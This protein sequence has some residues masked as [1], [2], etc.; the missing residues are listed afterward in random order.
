[1]TIEETV[2]ADTGKTLEATDVCGVNKEMVGFWF[3]SRLDDSS[4]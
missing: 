1:M 4:T 2:G 3:T